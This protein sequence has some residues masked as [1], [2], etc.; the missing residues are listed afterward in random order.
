NPWIRDVALF[1]ALNRAHGS[2]PF[3]QWSPPLR[4]RDAGA[5]AE[6]ERALAGD[7][8]RIAIALYFFENQWAELRAYCKSRGVRLLGD[9]P[10]YVDRN[11]A[12]VW[13]HPTLFHLDAEGLPTAVSG[14]PPDYF[15][16]L[17]QLWGN[18]LYRWDRMAADDF[19]WWRRRLARV[20]THTDI[21][22]ID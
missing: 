19:A 16:E 7:I 3:W 13:A 20:L 15:S 8:E 14:V 22:R 10:I 4:D 18:P 9:L 5:L 6:A 2:V 12:D 17:G 11:S 1:A 21:V